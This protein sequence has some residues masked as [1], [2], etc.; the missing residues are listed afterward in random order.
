MNSDLYII[1]HML[2]LKKKQI[3]NSFMTKTCVKIVNTKLKSE[4]RVSNFNIEKKGT[5]SK[6]KQN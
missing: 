4:V 2:N 5:M 6:Y 3:P 1:F